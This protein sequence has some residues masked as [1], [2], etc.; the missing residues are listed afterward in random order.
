M[1][2]YPAVGPAITKEGPSAAEIAQQYMH[3]THLGNQ[4][5]KQLDGCGAVDTAAANR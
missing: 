4:D 2:I 3:F 5:H 1:K